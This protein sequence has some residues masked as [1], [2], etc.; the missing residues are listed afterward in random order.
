[1]L[2][3]F[4]LY[5]STVDCLPF[6]FDKTLL[7]WTDENSGSFEKDWIDAEMSEVQPK[8]FLGRRT[9]FIEMN[10]IIIKTVKKRRVRNW[11]KYIRLQG[12]IFNEGVE[13]W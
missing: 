7:L 3:Y 13:K 5:I 12:L 9:N 8:K 11:P 4:S 10:K 1:M 6:C 2:Q